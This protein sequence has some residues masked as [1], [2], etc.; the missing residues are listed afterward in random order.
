MKVSAFLLS[1]A[2]L[3]SGL[4]GCKRD[5]RPPCQ[6]LVE[7]EAECGFENGVS[8]GDCQQDIKSLQMRTALDCLKAEDCQKFLSCRKKADE[9]KGLK[10][11]LENL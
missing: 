5:E 7:K 8:L 11:G 9:L 6:R 2:V 3:L 1:L 4:A 10:T